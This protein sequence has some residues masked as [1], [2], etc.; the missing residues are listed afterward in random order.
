MSKWQT[1]REQLGISDKTHQLTLN[2][3]EKYFNKV[4]DNVPLIEGYN[5]MADLLFLP[6]T[7]TFGG[8][9]KKKKEAYSQEKQ[10]REY[11]I[12]LVMVDLATDAFDIEEIPDKESSS[13]LDGM[14]RMFRR[15]YL[16]Q[17]KA[18]MRTDEGNEFMG[19]FTLWLRDHNIIHKRGLVGRHSQQANVERLNRTLGELFMGYLNSVELKTGR[20][21]N[22][23]TDILDE[24]RRKLN[25]IR[26]KAVP[27]NINTYQ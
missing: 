13:V 12:L 21:Y 24:V 14:L 20:P 25:A 2:T 15:P 23:W 4:K 26:K 9:K 22:E 17:P 27:E 10:P 5:Y 3:R 6:K 19:V 8:G 16:S 7:K 18:S 1:L 11:S